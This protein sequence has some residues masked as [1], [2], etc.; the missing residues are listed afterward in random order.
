[1]IIDIGNSRLTTSLRGM[2]MK[3]IF[4]SDRDCV[5]PSALL[6]DDKGGWLWQKINRLPNYYQM[7]DEIALLESSGEEISSFVQAGTALVDLGCG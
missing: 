4:E 1:L 7:R 3:R 6:S 5:L 2:L